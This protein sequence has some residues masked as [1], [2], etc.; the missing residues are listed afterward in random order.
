MHSN[1]VNSYRFVTL[2]EQ[3]QDA[4]AKWYDSMG[5][6]HHIPKSTAI[7]SVLSR[8]HC[9]TTNIAIH[10]NDHQ[11]KSGKNSAVQSS[12]HQFNNDRCITAY[13]TSRN[14]SNIELK[15]SSADGICKIPLPVNPA[16]NLPTYRG[17]HIKKVVKHSSRIPLPLAILRINK[18][19]RTRRYTINTTHAW[20]STQHTP[21]TPLTQTWLSIQTSYH[22]GK[23]SHNSINV[24]PKHPITYRGPLNFCLPINGNTTNKK[25]TLKHPP[26]PDEA[27]FLPLPHI[28]A[29][30]EALTIID[31]L[32]IHHMPTCLINRA[33]YT[34]E[35][36]ADKSTHNEV[37]KRHQLKHSQHLYNELL[38]APN[39]FGLT[40][41]YRLLSRFMYM[42]HSTEHIQGNIYTI[43]L[44]NHRLKTRTHELSDVTP[45]GNTLSNLSLLALS[46][47][48]IVLTIDILP[49]RNLDILEI[50][51]YTQHM[52]QHKS[53]IPQ[54]ACTASQNYLQKRNYAS[55]TFIYTY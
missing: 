5:I 7:N 17:T 15:R 4:F 49:R 45:K 32:T 38:P 8:S 43:R 35:I 19:A 52:M 1:R 27:I 54:F 26:E 18:I 51:T 39:S 34:Y 21:H 24:F 2:V 50:S 44:G 46:P 3:I 13:G 33:N 42:P 48:I 10:V 55:L 25:S 23:D 37:I 41:W 11:H 20:R 6:E 53:V 36:P 12:L 40:Y 28:K 31:S 29:T 30:F 14:C 47:I 9:R 16:R 22:N